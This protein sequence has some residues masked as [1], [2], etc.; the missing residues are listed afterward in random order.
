MWISPLDSCIEFCSLQLLYFYLSVSLCLQQLSIETLKLFEALLNLPHEPVLRNLVLR[1][2]EDRAYFVE[3]A[4]T[5]GEVT[6]SEAC[7]TPEQSN[8][9]SDDAKKDEKTA[10]EN[11]GILL[12]TSSDTF[13][14][15]QKIEKIVN[16]YKIL[17][18][19]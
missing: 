5:N 3:P 7:G 9:Q 18:L 1:N 17:H 13:F 15:K 8:E 14:D 19:N 2:L 12:K 4:M 6:S 11:E 16:G 10:N